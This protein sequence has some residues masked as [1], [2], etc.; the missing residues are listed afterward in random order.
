MSS[1]TYD[2]NALPAAVMIYDCDERLQTWNDNVAL[3]YPVITPWLQVGMPLAEL[4]ERF[5]DAVYNVD[6]GLRQTL[7]ESV[8]RNCRQDKHC[9]VR[10]VG[11]RRIFVQHQRLAD[12]GIVSLHSDITELDEAQRARHQ[13]HD[14]FLLTAESIHIG[15][16]DWQ[17]SGDALQVNDTLLAMLGQSRT[18]WR[19][20]VRFLLNQIHE[21]DRAALREA[22][23][24]SKQDHRPVFECE[25][26]VHHP[27]EG[28]RWM[29]LSGQVVTL[30]I[31]GNAERVIG[32]LQDIT[33]RKEAEIQAFASALEAQ[34]ANEAKSA[35]LA[36]MSHEIRTPMNGIIGM[37]QLCLDTTLNADQRDYLTLVMSSAQ[38]LLHIINDILD[39]SR[40]EAG[41]VELEA[42]PVP[43]RPFIQSLIRPH[44]PGASEKGI[45]LLVD[46]APDVPDVLLVDGARLRQ[47][48]TN[49]LGNALK[50]THQG[51]VILIVESGDNPNHWRFRVRDS[52]IG[53]P[54][55]KQK[56]IFEAFSQ[57]D[58]S[59]T[60]RYGGTG[61]GLTISSRLVAAMGGELTVTSEPGKGSEFSF[62]LPLS[63]Q[64][65]IPE[66]RPRSQRFN[67]EP[68]LV[69]DDNETNLRLLAAMLSQMGLK[70][71]CV[72]NA[73]EAIN[74]VK[75]SA[76]PLILLDAQMPDM[77][78]VSLALE[79]SVL[80]QISE[81]HIIML[82]SMSRHFDINM[83]KRIGIKNY[84]HK[85]IAQD[86]LHQAIAA[87]FERAPKTVGETAP[88][89][90]AAPGITGLRI[91]LAE[92]NLV[93]QKVAARLLER[94]G[95]T[96]QIV[97]NGVALLERWRTGVWD[98]LLIDLQMPE[99]DG[100][101]AI[102]LLREEECSR[103][104]PA[105][106]AVAMTAHAMQGDKERCLNMGFDGYIAKPISQ[107]RLAEEIAR[108]LERHDDSSVFPD[109]ARLL[110]QCADDPVLVQELLALF[111]EGLE[112]AI[113][114]IA[115]AIDND[116]REAL[117][118][119]AHKLRG[120]AVTL[121]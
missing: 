43:V 44:M 118:R 91:L 4:A 60:R 104:G 29:L 89:P 74:R 119:A 39:F 26:R 86:E 108:V 40:I 32:T 84:L 76:W 12:G 95:H 34:K 10:Q 17:V 36:N 33:R 35:F 3:F 45:E 115:L 121:D 79:L 5:I 20:P 106:P 68:V 14:D 110:K 64:C 101:T 18:Q 73:S 72:N 31:E 6:P 67:G 113:R 57:A 66:E 105:Q 21:D 111:G 88:A 92:D 97:D 49:L 16:W 93:N 96:C 62:V 37:T 63:T 42:E 9:E 109:E 80:P 107:E 22:L 87:A 120:E 94:L 2:L 8:V 47:V 71:T 69:V 82:S 58:N 98:V 23:H 102:R 50:F 103:H 81:S 112:E 55:D 56:A 53:I 52:G 28:L 27:T 7:R 59:T 61:L 99:M 41:K 46:I 70:P 25:I 117:R 13:L 24:A 15:I 19:Y 78:G 54:A 114:A 1:F 65:L 77:D 51:E 48:L 11:Q 85:P 100:E 30:S 90:V 38:S 83:L 75:A 116:D